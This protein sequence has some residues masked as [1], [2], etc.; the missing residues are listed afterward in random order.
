[1]TDFSANPAT[2]IIPVH[3]RKTTT[4]QCLQRLQQNGDLQH[5]AVVVVDDG[6]TDGTAA[7]IRS[8]FP[9]V[10][11]LT[12]DGHLWWTGAIRWGM[13]YA[14]QRGAACLIWLND[15]CLPRVGA[16]DTLVQVL[17]RDAGRQ[18]VGGMAAAACYLVNA[19]QPLEN[20]FR[21]RQRYTAKPGELIP[22]EGVTGYCV[23]ISREVVVGIG[24]PDAQRFPHYCGDDMYALKAFRAGFPVTI[25]GDAKVQIPDMV[26]ANHDFVSYARARFGQNLQGRSLFCSKKSR[27]YLPTQ[28]YYHLQKYG[29]IGPFLFGIKVLLW[30]LDYGRMRRNQ[31]QK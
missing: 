15:D 27:Y 26:E 3:N 9:T 21:G 28:F 25:V 30:L 29:A 14:Y 7:A 23:A 22:V 5:Y 11:V 19:D 10:D 4:L 24:L 12:G 1:M 31:V 2:L 17:Q 13:D 20:G 16:L 6:S 18:Q 8:A